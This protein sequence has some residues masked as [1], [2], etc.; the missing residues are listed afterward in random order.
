MPDVL[1]AAPAA[2]SA[3][4]PGG[5]GFGL[6]DALVLFLLVDLV[7]AVILGAAL[8]TLIAM[9]GL[10]CGARALARNRTGPARRDEVPVL[11]S[12]HAV[13][14]VRDAVGARR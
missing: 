7:L 8:W 1:D 13:P 10:W 5:D 2:M 3:L 4:T 12:L 11:L 6:V 14:P 9:Q